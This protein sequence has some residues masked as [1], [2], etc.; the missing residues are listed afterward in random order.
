MTNRVQLEYYQKLIKESPEQIQALR[1]L[2]SYVYAFNTRV[3][4]FDNADVRRALSMVID[5]EI[6]VEKVTGQGEPAAYSV[7]PDIIAGYEGAVP[8]FK[9]M[10]YSKE[11][12]SDEAKA[13]LACRSWLWPRVSR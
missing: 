13:I 11:L 12:D 10:Q 8:S 3:A 4:P 9:D 5:R 6:L 2:G 1:L 7:V